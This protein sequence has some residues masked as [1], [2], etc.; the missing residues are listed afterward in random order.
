MSDSARGLAHPR[1]PQIRLW[2]PGAG[3]GRRPHQDSKP[4]Y[5]ILDLQ[6]GGRSKKIPGA[7]VGQVRLSTASA[8]ALA[9]FVGTLFYCATTAMELSATSQTPHDSVIWPAT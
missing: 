2:G 7:C 4:P 8:P 1:R 3:F 5:A 9:T 6:E